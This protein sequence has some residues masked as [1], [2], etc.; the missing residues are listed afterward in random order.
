MNRLYSDL[1]RRTKIGLPI[2][3]IVFTGNV[4]IFR[5]YEH[6]SWFEVFYL[7][8]IT[9]TTVGYGDTTPTT[10]FGKLSAELLIL[11]GITTLAFVA[12]DIVTRLVATRN[13][14]LNPP[15]ESL[16]YTDHIIIGGFGSIGRRLARLFIEREFQVVIIEQSQEL[17][18]IAK[19]SGYRAIHADISKPNIL[20]KLGLRQAQALFL[21]LSNDE[22]TVQTSIL[23]RSFDPELDIYAELKTEASLKVAKFAGINYPISFVNATTEFID[24]EVR[25]H[26]AFCF[27]INDP[28]TETKVIRVAA[29]YPIENKFITYFDLAE[30]NAS[31]NTLHNPRTIKTPH[32]H[33]S[34]TLIAVNSKDITGQCDSK[35]LLDSTKNVIF[36][37]FNELAVALIHRFN[38][39]LNRITVLW[40]QP[41]EKTLGSQV[42]VKM[43]E[44]NLQT[45]K[46]LI[47][48]IVGEGSL[49]IS[50][51][52]DLT[53]ALLLTIT[54]NKLKTP[55]YM[56]QVV[57]YERE[58]ETF[59]RAGANNVVAVQHIVADA[60]FSAFLQVRHLPQ[61]IIFKNAQV[62]ERNVD[63][64]FLQQHKGNTENYLILLFKKQGMSEFKEYV[65]EKFEE[66][67][68]VL[69][70]RFHD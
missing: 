26:R 65:N 67:D 42:G 48:N 29:H 2:F 14:D 68:R 27:H 30:I 39:E 57:R 4:L 44:W 13:S 11:S 24:E 63:K 66:K 64:K 45:G 5:F 55:T 41:E 34:R 23:A 20:G 18:E 61:S 8:I 70:M 28:T 7:I 52:T 22:L 40:T 58:I 59:I 38:V 9:L 51:F 60:L 21:V 16:Q 6:F 25:Y 69:I 49:V 19:I 12:D 43:L 3:L 33:E 10:T 31:L 15:E 36:A 62:Y 53:S 35:G 56:I 50:Q 17:S 47:E 1:P 32:E 54:L 37:G 46:Q